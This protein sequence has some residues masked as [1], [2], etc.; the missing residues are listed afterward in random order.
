MIK[1]F[2][3]V[4]ALAMF[5]SSLRAMPTENEFRAT[6]V[7]TWEYIGPSQSSAATMEKIDEI[8]ENHAAANMTSV[9]FQVRQSGT[10]YY[11]SSFEPWG[12]YANY[13]NHRPQHHT[14]VPVFQHFVLF[15]L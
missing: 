7:I 11:E 2:L 12:Y 15:C 14:L 1:T 5:L 3:T 8:I 4:F 10:A 6:W 9:L 13:Q